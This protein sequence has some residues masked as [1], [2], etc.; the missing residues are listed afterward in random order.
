MLGSLRFQLQLPRLVLE[1]VPL[2]HGGLLSLWSYKT[3]INSFLYKLHLTMVY[4]HRHRKVM[5]TQLFFGIDLGSSAGK[6]S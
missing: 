5:H 2:C 4:Y 1:A 3:K 6:D